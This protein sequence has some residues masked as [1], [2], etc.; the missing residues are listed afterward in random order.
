MRPRRPL[1]NPPIFEAIVFGIRLSIG[2]VGE[3]ADNWK[4]LAGQPHIKTVMGIG[5]GSVSDFDFSFK[6][7][8]S[9][10]KFGPSYS[11]SRR[12][13]H[14]FEALTEFPRPEC[15]FWTRPAGLVICAKD[16]FFGAKHPAREV[17]PS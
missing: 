12:A 6:Q 8:G 9:T 10:L 7:S 15:I 3:Q 1:W 2:T 16:L 11:A 17:G 4:P 14:F 13:E 5:S